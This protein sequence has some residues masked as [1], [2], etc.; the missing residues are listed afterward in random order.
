MWAKVLPDK[1]DSKELL[2]TIVVAQTHSWIHHYTRTDWPYTVSSVPP[3]K[4]TLTI[5]T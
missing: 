2:M 1:I 4:E 3:P 5:R